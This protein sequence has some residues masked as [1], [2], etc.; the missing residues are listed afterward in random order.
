MIYIELDTD[1]F[2]SDVRAM[3]KAFY[4]GENLYVH[5]QR[6]RVVQQKRPR[7]EEPVR[8]HLTIGIH[9]GTIRLVI[10]ECGIEKEI[11]THNSDEGKQKNDLKKLLYE[12]LAQLTGQTLPWGTLTGIRPTKLFIKA[13]EQGMAQEDLRRTLKQEYLISDEK[14]KLGMEVADRERR[15]L[16]RVKMKQGYSLYVHIPFCPT[17]CLYCSFT[18]FPEAVFRPRM[19]EYVDCVIKELDFLAEHTKD[20][21]LN[22]IYIGGGTPTTLSAGQLHR[23]IGFIRERFDCSSVLEFTVEAGRPDS[24]TREKLEVL[25]AL[26]VTR[27]SIN[28]QTMQQKT[29]DVIGRG[30]TVEQTREAFFL[31]RECGFDNINMDLILGLPLETAEDVKDTLQQ[32]SRLK[33]D[34]LTVHCLARKHNARLNLEKD[35][36]QGLQFADTVSSMELAVECARNMGMIP[37]YLYRQKSIADNQENI[38]FSMEGKEGLYNILIMEERQSILAAGAGA[39]TKLVTTPGELKERV[40]TVKDVNAYLSR[41]QEMIQRKYDAMRRCGMLK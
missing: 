7:E 23:L 33:P 17:T 39:I 8:M 5:A 28:P 4:P 14:L 9:G 27:I 3:V 31:A 34:N 15:I 26:G 12:V 6:S 19:E 29:L 41:T 16:S 21:C 38:G 37:Y 18:S 1:R 22:S 13:M 35:R 25:K 36:Y 2:E 30:H 20:F 10:R 11:M 32:I 24:I 40:E